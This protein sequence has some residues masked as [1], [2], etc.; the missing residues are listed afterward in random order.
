[1]HDGDGIANRA[2]IDPTV[3]AVVVLVFFFFS[4]F[5]FF[6]FSLCL[7]LSLSLSLSTCNMRPRCEGSPVAE[8]GGRGE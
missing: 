4:F 6:F 8:T 1:L 5:F 3:A 2:G 7:S